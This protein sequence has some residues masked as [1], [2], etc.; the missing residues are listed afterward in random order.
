MSKTFTLDCRENPVN[1]ITIDT[2]NPNYTGLVISI[3]SDRGQ[4]ERRAI[5]HAQD[6]ADLIEALK[7]TIE[8]KW[9]FNGE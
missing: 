4:N 6:V 9:R 2:N 7:E 8:L 5:L 3:W 1:S